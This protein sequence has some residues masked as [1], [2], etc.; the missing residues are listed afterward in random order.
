MSRRP[1]PP[2]DTGRNGFRYEWDPGDERPLVIYTV[3]FWRDRLEQ[4]TYEAAVVGNPRR[5]DE[6]AF[7]YIQRIS[8]IVTEE[9][10]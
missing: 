3:P 4:A 8:E 5:E 2:P 1:D 6:G 10:P 7:S 9:R